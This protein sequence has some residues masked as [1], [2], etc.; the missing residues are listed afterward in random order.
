VV[1]VEPLTGDVSILDAV[2]AILTGQAEVVACV[3]GAT[4]SA[5]VRRVDG[6][7][8]GFGG[9]RYGYPSLYGMIGAVEVAAR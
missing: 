8:G 6:K 4:P 1:K 2:G 7:V 5:G 9:F 3:Y